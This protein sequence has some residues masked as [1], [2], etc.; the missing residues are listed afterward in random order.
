M[1]TK[2]VV[3]K[4]ACPVKTEEITFEEAVK[5]FKT[6]VLLHPSSGQRNHLAHV[7]RG[8]AHPDAL[9]V[10]EQHGSHVVE[11]GYNAPDTSVY[12]NWRL[13]V[14]ADTNVFIAHREI[15]PEDVAI[16]L[17]ISEET[18]IDGLLAAYPAAR[19][20]TMDVTACAL[21]AGVASLTEAPVVCRVRR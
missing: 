16:G 5:R 18:A 10:S 2:S 11:P 8:R 15:S 3:S 19:G 21:G 13:Y 1:K 6:Q 14:P 20:K 4:L 17:G 9:W 12:K 7:A